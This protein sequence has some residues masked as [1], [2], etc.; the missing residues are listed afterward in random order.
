MNLNRGSVYRKEIKLLETKNGRKIYF[1]L[2][3]LSIGIVILCSIGI[4]LFGGWV[5]NQS[6]IHLEEN[7]T[8]NYVAGVFWSLLFSSLVWV[9]IIIKCIELKR[10]KTY[11]VA[12]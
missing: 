3:I 4:G 1:Y 12:I 6:M 2:H 10:F 8:R 5:L 7:D 11:D 9:K